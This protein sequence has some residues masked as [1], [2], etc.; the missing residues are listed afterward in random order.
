MK[1]GLCPQGFYSSLLLTS[2]CRTFSANACEPPPAVMNAIAKF[3]PVLRS[4][5]L[6]CLPGYRFANGR[7]V[8]I[9]QCN[10]DGSWASID[11]CLS[12]YYFVKS[13]HCYP[14]AITKNCRIG[15]VN[16]F[17]VLYLGM[18]TAKIYILPQILNK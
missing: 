14:T 3:D 18:P 15:E 10:A 2:F 5:S 1:L 13:F 16:N 4:L 11:L 7:R 8:S 6:T 9:H 17:Q 12:T